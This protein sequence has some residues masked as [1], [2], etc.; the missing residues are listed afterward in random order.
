ML[1]YW[2]EQ[3]SH[4]FVPNPL[5]THPPGRLFCPW[6]FPGKNTGVSCHFFLQG[7]FPI[8]GSN[9]HLQ[10]LLHFQVDSLPLSCLGRLEVSLPPASIP[11]AL[12]TFWPLCESLVSQPHQYS[13]EPSLAPAHPVL[14]QPKLEWDWGVSPPCA[15]RPTELRASTHGQTL[16]AQEIAVHGARA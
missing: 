9:L 12:I 6:D 11:L 1:R 13:G 14:F 15:L 8:Q 4:S 10:C 7:I 2:C 16:L 5:W 3:L